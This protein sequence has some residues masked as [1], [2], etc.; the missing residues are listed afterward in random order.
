MTE[1]VVGCIIT[2]LVAIVVCVINNIVQ[3]QNIK[4]QN[5]KTVAVIQYQIQDL[6]KS[7]EKHNNLV[8]RMAVVERDLKTSFNML[9]DIREDISDLKRK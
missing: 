5:D 2:G 8:E 7:V 9:D 4:T 6:T 1:T 3:A